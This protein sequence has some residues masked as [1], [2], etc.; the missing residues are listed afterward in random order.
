MFSNVPEMFA[1]VDKLRELKDQY[2]EKRKKDLNNL[3]EACEKNPI[4]LEYKYFNYA[5]EISTDDGVKLK[6]NNHFFC[7]S[8]YKVIIETNQL[9]KSEWM[10]EID[11]ELFESE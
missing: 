10:E 2:N 1:Y 6:I 8:C 7:K 9:E 5:D 4:E 11:K 3:C